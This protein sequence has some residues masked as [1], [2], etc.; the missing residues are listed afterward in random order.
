[1]QKS[2]RLYQQEFDSSP[3]L[4]P[5]FDAFR[6]CFKKEITALLK[7]LGAIDIKIKYGH[8]KVNGFF[9]INNQAWWFDTGDVRL[10]IMRNMLIR[11]AD[12][13]NDFRGGINQFVGYDGNFEDNL[14]RILN[15]GMI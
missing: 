6:K 1:M 5:Q 10:K 8:F 4:T 3:G 11:K 12:N 9:T 2:I 13:Y 14:A 7:S 15:W